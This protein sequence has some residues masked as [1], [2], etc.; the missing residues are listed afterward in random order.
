MGLLWPHQS[1]RSRSQDTS[2]VFIAIVWETVT[3]CGQPFCFLKA[4]PPMNLS[5]VPFEISAPLPFSLWETSLTLQKP[6][7]ATTACK[8]CGITGQNPAGVAA[9]CV[10]S[11]VAFS[12]AK[13]WGE[14]V[15][16]T[17]QALEE[18]SYCSCWFYNYEEKKAADQP[19]VQH[20]TVSERTSTFI[21]YTQLL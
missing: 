13:N 6:L 21:Q 19:R 5:E 14:R 9:V 7:G 2:P 18:W 11:D 20:R 1:L 16:R 15:T 3:C 4:V 12:L 10:T 17:T 8:M